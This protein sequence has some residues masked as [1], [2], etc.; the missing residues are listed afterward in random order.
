[1]KDCNEVVDC[2]GRRE[3]LVKSAFVAG[4]LVLTVTGAAKAANLL[5]PFQ[6]L[7]ITIDDKSP[8]KKVG[9]STVVDSSAGK[10]IVVRTG[11]ATFVAFSAICTHKRGE[12][13]YDASA[14]QFECPKH[15][16]K[17]DGATG[18]VLDGPADDPLPSYS[19]KGT[20]TSVTVTV[21]T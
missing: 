9:G 17:F 8:L 15:H 3:F 7:V 5:S 18:K 10:L 4:G 16:S 1:V 11:D 13:E 14:K 20:A 6:D 2:I 12:I 19:A 21:G